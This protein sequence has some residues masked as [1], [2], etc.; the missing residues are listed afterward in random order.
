MRWPTVAAAISDPPPASAR[1][2]SSDAV[3]T[4]TMSRGQSAPQN[5]V[6]AR[7]ASSMAPVTRSS[8]GRAAGPPRLTSSTLRPSE[9]VT[10]L[11]ATVDVVGVLI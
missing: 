9:T 3:A 1:N 4:T 7:T 11:E 2:C 6:T 10:V 8:S 5:A